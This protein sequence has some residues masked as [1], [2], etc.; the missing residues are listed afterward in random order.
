VKRDT[1]FFGVCL[2][3][4]ITLL[5]EL[6]FFDLSRLADGLSNFGTLAAESVPPETSVLDTLIDALWET[7][8][9]AVAGTLLG[10]FIALPFGLIGTTTLMPAAAIAPVRLLVAITRTIPS[11]VWAILFVIVV[12]LGPLAGTLGIAV[13]TLGYLGK[14]YAELFDGVDPEVVEAVAGT[15]AS[16]LQLARF[17]LW[18]EAANGVVSQL[19]FMVEYNIRASSILGFVGAGGIGFYIQVYVQTLQYD[20]LLTVL[21]LLLAVVLAMDVISAWV[22]RRYL[23]TQ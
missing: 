15:G 13:Y 16:R 7:V 9:M 4:L 18:P 14:L 21:L 8:Q 1:F 5:A 20:R 23:L 19:L 17:V 6:G 10:F 12:G 22:R 11:L 3:V 2:L